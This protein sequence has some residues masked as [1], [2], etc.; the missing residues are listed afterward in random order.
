MYGS[1]RGAVG[2]VLAPLLHVRWLIAAVP[3]DGKGHASKADPSKLARYS[4]ANDR[5]GQKTSRS[6]FPEQAGSAA[7]GVVLPRRSLFRRA[8]GA[9]RRTPAAS[10][11]PRHASERSLPGV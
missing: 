1:L 8:Q 9:G 11:E 3:G 2:T 4:H 10:L 7:A 6:R 5:F